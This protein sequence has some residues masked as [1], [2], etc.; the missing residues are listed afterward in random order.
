[1]ASILGHQQARLSGPIG[2]ALLHQAPL[3]ATLVAVVGILLVHFDTALSI[4]AIWRRSDTFAHGYLVVPIA[5]WLA[6]RNRDAIVAAPALPWTPALALVALAGALWFVTALADV[7][8]MRQFALAFMLQSAIVAV[9]GLGVARA[10]VFPLLFLLFA[11]PAGDFLVPKMIELTADF[12]V[13]ALR[14]SG[15]PVYREANHFIIPSGAW[16]VVEACSGLRYLIASMMIGLLF[17]AVRYRSPQRRVAFIAASI[18]VPLV[19]NWLRAYMI[20]MLGH[21]SDNT[22]AVGVDHL[23]YGW[24]FF[25]IVMGLLFW[26][27]SFWSEDAPLTVTA[28][29]ALAVAG[30]RPP[31]NAARFYAVAVIA[32]GVAAIWR[33]IVTTFER[34]ASTGAVTIAPIDAA[35]GWTS[36]DAP[37]TA[38]LPSYSG[39][40]ARRTQAFV[41]DGAVA[42]VHVEYYRDQRKGEELVTSANQ[43]VQPENNRWALVASGSADVMLDGTRQEAHRA[44]IVGDRTRLVVYRL[45]W[46]DG[47]ITASDLAAKTLL[48]WSRLTGGSG[49]AALIVVS[50]RERDDSDTAREALQA[51]WPSISRSLVATQDRR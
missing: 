23:I 38:W 34:P 19:A 47:R 27:G 50:A 33:P 45:Y 3:Y 8:V 30:E 16:S 17:A 12:T 10:I 41:R 20:V 40:K 21:L 2:G 18:V 28:G 6:W 13:A 15:V 36:G 48:A 32:I 42:G 24:V 9:V 11:V 4:E 51:L 37:P 44:I 14:A 5:V 7:V 49:D 22:I 43:L 35:A 39:A 46:I 26:V 25:G 31:G 1:M 29:P